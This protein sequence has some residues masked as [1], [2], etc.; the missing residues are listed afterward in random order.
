MD[1]DLRIEDISVSRVHSFLSIVDRDFF[2]HDNESKFGTLVQLQ[3]P[4]TLEFDEMAQLQ[5]G[6]TVLGFNLNK[7]AQRKTGWMP[8]CCGSNKS[9]Q[10]LCPP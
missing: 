10:R 2:L 1:C 8:G 4:L 6:R 5:V 7:P 9:R 3:R